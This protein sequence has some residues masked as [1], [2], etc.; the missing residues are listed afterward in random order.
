MDFVLGP[1]IVLSYKRLS[2]KAWYAL[3]EF[4]DN[5]TQSYFLNQKLLDPI[6]EAKGDLLTVKITANADYVRIEDNSIGMSEKELQHAVTLGKPPVNKGGRSQYGL[7]LKTAAFWFGNQVTITTK[8]LGA[9]MATTV[10]LVVDDIAAGK[11]D[12]H[13][14]KVKAGV[15]EHYT[16]ILIEKLNVRI[17]NRSKAKV[18][19]FLT[20]FYKVDLEASD[21]KLRLL[22]NNDELTW[23]SEAEINKKLRLL[24]SGRP[25]KKRIN[26][27]IGTGEN[28]KTVTGWAGVLKRGS[29]SAGGFSLLQ[30]KRVVQTA[31]KPSQIFGEQEGGS[32][33][34]VNQ[35]L[36]GD[37]NV[38]KF[39]ISHTKDEI[40]FTDEEY[41]E[42]DRKLAKELQDLVDLANQSNKDVIPPSNER[43]KFTNLAIER[44]DGE[45]GS[46]EFRDAY[47]YR[48]D[49][50]EDLIA[51]SKRVY[52]LKVKKAFQPKR[53]FKVGDITVHLY[54]VADQSINDLYLTIESVNDFHLDV[55][56]NQSHP[57][58]YQ[59]DSLSAVLNFLRHCIYDGLAEWK[60]VKQYKR[61]NSDTIKIFKDKF[62]R[63]PFEMDISNRPAPQEEQREE[64]DADV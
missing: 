19:S 6:Y 42:L 59:L 14:K 58:W 22:F 16:H 24:H 46:D 62:L 4:I 31:F 17:A 28:K 11:K 52:L 25:A 32:N 61:I 10:T 36:I 12:V 30:A 43:D 29:R 64:V 38:D 15:N 27:T 44:L 2:Y 13:L 33:N 1:E 21:K 54:L 39:S 47:E 37:L 3:A 45:I 56:V 9:K 18:K 5:S 49:S 20:T 51:F 63:I 41:E 50:P 35:R 7:G 48:V 23:D 26:L 60:C 40:L 57:H 55:I 53:E 8:K 34:L